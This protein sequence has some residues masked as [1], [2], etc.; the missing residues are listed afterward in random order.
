MVVPNLW[1]S[2]RNSLSRCGRLLPH[3]HEKQERHVGSSARGFGRVVRILRIDWKERPTQDRGCVSSKIHASLV[4][5]PKYFFCFRLRNADLFPGLLLEKPT[6][7]GQL[8]PT[9][10]CLLGEFFF[11]VKQGD[12]FF[13]R[14]QDS[15]GTE[16]YNDGK[17]IKTQ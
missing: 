15:L 6:N 3:K 14:N 8:G 5:R 10:T 16:H 4:F 2:F 7:F 12:R 17:Q 1:A 9:L 13:Y 11:S